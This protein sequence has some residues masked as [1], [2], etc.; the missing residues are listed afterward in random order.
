MRVVYGLSLALL[1]P[2]A[3]FAKTGDMGG[4]LTPPG[5][6]LQVMGKAQGYDLSKLIVAKP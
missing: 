2:G 1:L 3:A 4:V 6:T 5:I